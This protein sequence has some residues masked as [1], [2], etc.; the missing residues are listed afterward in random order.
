MLIVFIARDIWILPL[1]EAM[2]WKRV[3]LQRY[4]AIQTKRFL[5]HS[6]A[7]VFPRNGTPATAK[8]HHLPANI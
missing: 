5:L 6:L 1:K 7:I 4:D 8:R 2:K 3:E